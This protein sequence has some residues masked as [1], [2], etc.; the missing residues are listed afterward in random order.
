MKS[1]EKNLKK[2]PK[3]SKVSVYPT[4]ANNSEQNNSKA[5]IPF[6]VAKDLDQFTRIFVT[7][8]DD[9]FKVVH[10]C[11]D[12]SSDYKI[13]GELPDGDRQL[14]FT[15]GQ[16]FE[17]DFCSCLDTCTCY[18][19]LCA[20]VCCNS[21]VFQM[22][23]ERN[24]D[25]FYTQGLNIQKGLYFCE[26][27]CCVCCNNCTRTSNLF[28]RENTEPDNPDFNVGTKKGRTEVT[29]NCC[30]PEYTSSYVTQDG[31]KGQGIRVRCCEVYKKSCLKCC[32]CG[33]D[34][35]FEMDI[36]DEK[37]TKTGNIMIYSGCFSKKV[38]GKRCYRPRKYYEINMPKN[39]NSEQKFQ[40]IADLI[41]FDLTNGTL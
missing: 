15:C 23:Y 36:E 12:L 3:A 32:C 13:Y 41:H 7:K 20:Y 28:L 19:G 29:T 14:L 10:I 5:K 40:I 33:L 38:E 9:L 24:G 34:C 37:G 27:Y 17:C 30:I 21:I 6:D 26:C 22:D 11:E 8:E 39:A 18:L 31:A 25:P 1:E 16:H 2:K 35:D 4:N